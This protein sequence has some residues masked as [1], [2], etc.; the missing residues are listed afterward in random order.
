MNYNYTL[1]CPRLSGDEELYSKSIEKNS[2]HFS[3]A[4]ILNVT[5][6]YPNQTITSKY[7]Q[8]I[9]TIRKDLKENDILIFSHNDTGIIDDFFKDKVE[10]IFN[11]T[12][13]ALIG[14]VGSNLLNDDGCWWSVPK[15]NQR[16]HLIQ[17]N[18]SNNNQFHLQKGLIGFFDDIVVIDGLIMITLGKYLM[19]SEINF[20]INTCRNNFYDASFCLDYLLN[21]Y[22]IVVADILVSHKSEGVSNKDQIYCEDRDKFI[23]KYKD[24][25]LDFP[26]TLKSIKNKNV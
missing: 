20:D 25:S 22:K 18:R 23:K 26:I 21:G 12:D 5:D 17:G 9:N 10:H 15:D 24:L 7:N 8:A 19:N 4:R 13:A 16:G 11:N 1:I 2:H 3:P 6:D 14:V